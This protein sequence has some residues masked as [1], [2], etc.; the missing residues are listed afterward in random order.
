MRS[1]SRLTK[2]GAIG[3][4][5]VITAAAVL[6]AVA[7]A[8]DAAEGGGSITVLVVDRK[9]NE[10]VIGATVVLFRHGG[11]EE[12]VALLSNEKGLARFEHLRPN[13]YQVGVNMP[14]YVRTRVK[15]E[16]KDRSDHRVLV[17][18][19]E[20]SEVLLLGPHP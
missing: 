2:S 6:G 9:S 17:R 11:S 15:V 19:A 12:P 18:L 13:R 10:P 14:G 3:V 16:V 5:F 1:L 4:V 20:A 7:D 8:N